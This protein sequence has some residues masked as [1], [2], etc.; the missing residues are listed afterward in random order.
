MSPSPRADS[1]WDAMIYAKPIFLTAIFISIL[2][3]PS[4]LFARTWLVPI[5]A[6]TIQAGID[7][8]VAGE[9]VEVACGTYYEHN[10]VMKSGVTLRS[11]SG[12][13]Q[14]VTVDALQ[15]GRV[16]YCSELA[17]TTRVDGFTITGGESYDGAGIY[18]TLGTEMT[19]SNCQFVNNRSQWAAGIACVLNSAPTISFCVFR[20][21]ITERDGGGIGCSNSH[22]TVLNCTFYRNY[23]LRS[24]S[25][26]FCQNGANAELANCILAYNSSDFVFPVPVWC[27]G[28]DSEVSMYDCNVWGFQENNWIQCISG[29][30]GVNGNFSAEPGFCN[31][32]NDVLSLCADSW[33][34]AGTL[35]D[36]HYH[37]LIG[38][39]GEGCGD[40]GPHVAETH[41]SWG[42]VKAL[43][44]E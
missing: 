42:G 34:L 26:I 25:A 1:R 2:A 23:S 22:V 11:E 14:C 13:Y 35:P 29:L 38:A 40:C 24:G 33:C 16:F 5:D 30:S 17:S 15:R 4:Y 41:S 7:S 12:D 27:S 20:R 8:A 10:I 32:E 9:I 3:A 39:L 18:C 44:K 19:I 36:G 6:P 37:D 28:E 21:N 31:P 43:Y